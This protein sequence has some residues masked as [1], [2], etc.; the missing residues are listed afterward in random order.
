M[1]PTLRQPIIYCGTSSKPQGKVSSSSFFFFSSAA[2]SLHLQ[3][4]A[5][6]DWAAC[7][8]THHSVTGFY[9]FIGDSLLF[10]KSKKQATISR[11]SVESEYRALASVAS[12][13]TWMES[14]LKD[15]GLSVSSAAVYCNG[16]AAIH[17]TSNPT[18]HEGTKHI[19]VDCHFIQEKV[20][21]GTIRLVHVCTQHQTADLL[22]KAL[23]SPQF[24]YLLSKMGVKNIFRPGSIGVGS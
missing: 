4:Y 5:D 8:D 14:L 6:A 22:T 21:N 17:I 9:V 23:P 24:H 13:L 7:V 3:A 18:Y 12:E 10:W 11:S 2:S 15:F 1:L 19:E 20:T 16:Q